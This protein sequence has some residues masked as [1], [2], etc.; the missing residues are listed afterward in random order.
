MRL[1]DASIGQV[2]PGEQD[3]VLPRGDA[4]Q[5]ASAGGVDLLQGYRCSL[6]RLIRGIANFAKG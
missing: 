1:E 2:K 6:E 5:H 4:M 3:E